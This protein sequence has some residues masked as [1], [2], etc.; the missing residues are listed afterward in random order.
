VA[1]IVALDDMNFEQEVL[2]SDLPVLVDCWAGWCGPCH[3]MEPEIHALA[4]SEADR[5]KVTSL[6]T[7]H[8]P[9]VAQ[10]YC[11]DIEMLPTCLL[12][13]RGEIVR[14]IDGY[15]TRDEILWEVEPYLKRRPQDTLGS[16]TTSL[17]SEY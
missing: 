1:D 6:D 7:E 15:H 11:G 3:L 9:M 8:Y 10:D 5:L 17:S 12:F 14:R 13:V 2:T 4:E 16:A